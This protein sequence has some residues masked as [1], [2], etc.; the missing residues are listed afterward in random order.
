VEFQRAPE[1]HPL[2]DV[3]VHAHDTQ[4]KPALLEVQVKRGITFSPTDPIFRSVI[5]QI[6]EVAQKP[7]F[8]NSRY[9]LGIAISRTSQKIDGAYSA[10]AMEFSDHSWHFVDEVKHGTRYSLLYSFW[11]S[12]RTEQPVV[13]APGPRIPGEKDFRRL[14]E[15]L[16]VLGADAIPHSNGFLMDHLIGTCQ[17]L[18]GWQSDWDICKAGLFHSIADAAAIS[19]LGSRNE[20]KNTLRAILGERSLFLIRLYQSLDDPALDQL[21]FQRDFWENGV[22]VRVHEQDLRAVVVLVWAS[23]L[24]KARRLPAPGAERERLQALYEKTKELMSE[25]TE[26]DVAALLNTA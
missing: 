15:L 21:L 2:D 10:V 25:A 5:R 26:R 1:G 4:G 6:A 16:R 12:G 14:Y 11:K 18:Q 24:E 9:E 17:I 23:I 22:L 3:I 7:E 19:S 20:R 8:L 13:P